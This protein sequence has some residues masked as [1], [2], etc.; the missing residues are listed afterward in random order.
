MSFRHAVVTA[1]LTI[2]LPSLAAAQARPQPLP[3]RRMDEM[4]SR[5]VQLYFQGGG[6]LVLVPFGPIS[7]HGA[8]IPL[9]MHNH[10]AH[11]LAVLIAE[12]ANGLVHPPVFSCY[13]GAT[14]SF[15]GSVSFPISEQEDVLVRIVKTLQAQGFKRIV[16]VAG[17]HP[18]DTGG[19]LAARRVFDETEHPIWLLVGEK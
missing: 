15:R 19:M 16:L 11:A 10:W 4:T 2:L 12:R 6:D 7:G 18:E 1:A 13:S 17:T 3:T 9:G 8:F 14:R 5:E